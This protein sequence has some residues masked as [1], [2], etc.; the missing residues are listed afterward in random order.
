[1]KPSHGNDAEFVTMYKKSERNERQM[2]ERERGVGKREE[3][4]K[5][6]ALY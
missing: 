1:M 3:E 2:K 5:D 4:E 6:T